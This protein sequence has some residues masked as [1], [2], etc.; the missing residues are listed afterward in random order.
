MF[1]H[2][3]YFE[4]QVQGARSENC[5]L[6][7]TENWIANTSNEI[8]GINS[9]GGIA[10]NNI[11]IVLDTNI[12]DAKYKDVLR[13]GDFVMLSKLAVRVYCAKA[14]SIPVEYDSTKYTDVPVSHVLGKFEDNKISFSTFKLLGDKVLLK[15][16]S[17]TEIDVV[18]GFQVTPNTTLTVYDIVK[19][20]PDVQNVSVGQRILLRDNVAVETFLDGEQ[21][22]VTDVETV[23]GVFEGDL[24]ISK[25]TPCNNCIILTEYIPERAA[26]SSIIYNPSYDK[27][28]DFDNRS[29]IYTEETY[30]VLVSA[31]SSLDPQ[32]IVYMSRFALEY[33]TFR[34]IKYFVAYGTKHMLATVKEIKD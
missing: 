23:V 28:D 7:D 29:E 12:S 1:K 33:I 19:V 27:K 18:D 9:R 22:F 15:R 24:D 6:V 25:V 2:K 17:Y 26:G 5:I 32:D 21:Y 14:Y 20:G 16:V 34:G 8:I 3:N 4:Y 11:T 10:E 31:E 30:R 13:A